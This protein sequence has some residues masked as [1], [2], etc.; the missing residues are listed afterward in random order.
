[1]EGIHLCVDMKRI[2]VFGFIALEFVLF[3]V[4]MCWLC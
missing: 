1:M 2:C 3:L 4:C